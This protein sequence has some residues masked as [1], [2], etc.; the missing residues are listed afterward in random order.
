MIETMSETGCGNQ[1]QFRGKS[2]ITWH[3]SWQEFG[4]IEIIQAENL[5]LAAQVLHSHQYPIVWPTEKCKQK[6]S[7]AWYLI[8]THTTLNNK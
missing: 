6:L 1:F 2:I 8:F 4:W 7:N 3:Q 5:V